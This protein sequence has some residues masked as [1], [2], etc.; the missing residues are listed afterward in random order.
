MQS[1]ADGELRRLGRVHEADRARSAVIDARRAGFDNVSLDL[2]MWLPGQSVADWM[3][4][5]EALA[6]LAPEH[7]SL[8]MLELYP[9]APLRDEM[10]RAGWSQAPDDDAADM[11]DAAMRTLEA[12]GYRQYEISNVARPGRACRHNLKYWTDGEWL[13]VGPG[14]HSTWRGVRWKSVSSTPDYVARIESGQDVDVERRVLSTLERA[15][16]AVITGLRLTE[17]IDPDRLRLNY[18]LD[19]WSEYGQYLQPYLDAGLLRLE[20][21]RLRLSRQGMLL[22]NE[23][24]AVFV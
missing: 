14:A 2:M 24:L 17:G 10:A 19:I 5:V 8:Y 23:V 20:G 9:N 18:G 11:Y 3:A 1:F 12:V 7:A 21:G 6:D 16:E 4:N 22:A 15:Q 13:G